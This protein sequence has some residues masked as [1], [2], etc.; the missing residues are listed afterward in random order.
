MKLYKLTDQ[1]NETMNHTMWGEGVTHTVSGTG[2]LCG[3]GWLH[4]Y[5]H[6]LIALFMNPIHG[7]FESPRLWLAEG[8]IGTRDGELKCG[9]ASLTTITE[10]EVPG[11]TIDFR[12]TVAI[13][14]ALLSHYD[15]EFTRWAHSWLSGKDRSGDA[16]RAAAKAAWAADARAAAWAA[17]AAAWA[18]DAWAAYA[19]A[20]DARAAWAAYAAAA[21]A[22][23][24]WAADAGAAAEAA[25]AA[26]RAAWAADRAAWAAD[27]RAADA[28]AAAEAAWA[29]DRLPIL[30]TLTATAQEMG[31]G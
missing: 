31:I 14:L 9:V 27:A 2:G 8:E 3:P 22:R 19:A 16:A 29:A 23:A 24:A 25:W 28:R 6:P 10:L 20:A 4:A 21:D 11:L 17:W 15:L 12:V 30:G 26:D 13:K 5:E 7:R 18:A 1:N